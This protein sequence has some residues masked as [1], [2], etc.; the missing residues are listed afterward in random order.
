M[1]MLRHAIGLFAKCRDKE[2]AHAFFGER[3]REEIGRVLTRGT[4]A[5][6]QFAE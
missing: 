5:L 1:Q 6:S 2:H 4:I 3:R